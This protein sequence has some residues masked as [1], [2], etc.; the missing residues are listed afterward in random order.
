[1]R[2][3][4]FVLAVPAL[5]ADPSALRSYLEGAVA[6][7][8]VAG[9]VVVVEQR[10][11][12]VFREAFGMADIAAG[13][14]MAPDNLF[15]MASS[16]KPFSATTVMTL[17]DQGKLSL[18]DRVS[19][20]YLE[21]KGS[22]TVR[23]LL[24]HTSGMF[25]ND[26]PPEAVKWIR[27]LS[28]SVQ[29]SVAGILSVP[30]SY[31]PGAKYAY[32]GASFEVAGGIVEK[33][34]GMGYEAYMRK[35]LLD[36]LGLDDTYFHTAKDVGDRV[37]VL[38]ASREGRLVPLPTLM[39]RVGKRGPRSGGFVLVAGG[40]Y[41]TADDC[42]RFLR[43]HVDGG[44][45]GDR[46]IVSRRSVEE[47]RTKQTGELAT[48]YGLGWTLHPTGAVGH[49]GA[50]GTDLWYHP[51]KGLAV[52]VMIQSPGAQEFQRKVRELVLATW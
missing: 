39:D 36:P 50:Y 41:S 27:T 7:K 29:E 6:A 18:D 10:G 12:V 28:L 15:M 21:F 44:V 48:R 13:R 34:A 43:M 31:E 35:V 1:M 8:A 14:R 2:L 46:R 24:S 11:T 5:A 30:L 33:V 38:Y 23:Q 25:G 20:F 22:S 3:A 16:T 45:V 37:P 4:W 9:A 49:G 51:G 42:I 47:M 26:G 40:L 52:A 19:K 17:V 32:G